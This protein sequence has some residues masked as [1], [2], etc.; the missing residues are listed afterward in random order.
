MSSSSSF[1]YRGLILRV[2]VPSP[3]RQLFEY[4]PPSEQSAVHKDQGHSQTVQQVAPGTRV[5]V[6]FGRRQVVG[7]VMAT[8]DGSTL[9]RSR[10]RPASAVLDTQPL[11]SAALFKVL[12]W[13]MEYYHHPPGEVMAAA[14]PAR[15]RQGEALRGSVEHWRISTD[16]DDV[17]T[18]L[19]RAPR[20]RELYDWI[21]AEGSI[22]RDQLSTSPFS[23]ALLRELEAR[24]LIQRFQV[25]SAAG[26]HFATDTLIAG[27]MPA[28]NSEQQTAVDRIE[29]ALDH[30]G[31]FLLDGVT[32]SGKTE[33][34][35]Q[36]MSKV[37][38]AGRQCLVLVPEIGLTPQTINRFQ[39]RFTCPVVSLHSG[40]NDSERLDAWRQAADGGAGIVIGTR[41]AVFCELARP[42]LIVVDEE[43]DSSFKQQDGFRYSARDLAI[44]R[45]R[46]SGIPVILGSATPS[47]ESLLNA[48]RGRYQH[49][50]LLQRAGLAEPAAL[51]LVDVAEQPLEAGFADHVLQK[52]AIQ[53]ER[54]NQVLAFINRRGFAPLLHCLTCGWV[55]EC[56]HCLTQL[57][58]HSQPRGL[59]CHHCG[60]RQSLPPACPGCHSR[61]LSTVGVGTQQ[62]EAAL[63]SRFAAYPVLRIDR[64]S[65]RSRQRFTTMLEQVQSGQP[66][67]LI[68]T[69]MLAKGHH[70]PGITLVV[71]I[72]ADAGLFSADF[73]GQEQMAQTIVQVAGRAGRAEL[74]GEVLIQ[75]RHASH[76]TLQA[77]STLPYADFARQLLDARREAELPPFSH[78]A[79]LR[80]EARS[81]TQSLEFLDQAARLAAGLA[82]QHQ[83]KVTYLGPVPSPME[84]RAGRFRAQLSISS[85]ER[86]ALQKQLALLMAELDQ[87]KTPAGLRW[88]LDVDPL[89]MV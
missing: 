81:L 50:R 63:Q 38:K 17:D 22:S 89:D 73:R 54:G 29:R 60:D 76:S 23:T 16:A 55:A 56:E 8:A 3:L 87:I 49:L 69:Q 10:L 34:Y 31:C 32:G 68:G 74:G 67:L 51:K 33:V 66:C 53:L 83:L 47:L 64:D 18:R 75:S 58:V 28:L 27:T 4:L 20:Q 15:L 45:A 48:E 80:S 41:S 77:L 39:Q 7:V 59:R 36:A 72:D 86:G 19:A 13:A 12:G 57:T 52:M 78:L 1:Q 82:S 43:H 35:M 42:G 14:L 79:L 11:F 9:P 40:M 5:K 46:E 84:K 2:A 70:F 30:F 71:V 65:T 21:A 61:D 88:S 44:L 24:Q 25:N 85:S 26:S 37:L 62:I 6:P